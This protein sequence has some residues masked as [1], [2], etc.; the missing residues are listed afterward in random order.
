MNGAPVF[1]QLK[2]KETVSFPV[3]VFLYSGVF[4]DFFLNTSYAA[5]SQ[6]GETNGALLKR[7]VKG[8]GGSLATLQNQLPQARDVNL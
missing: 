7:R 8:R 2:E 5:T 6:K 3:I 1:L 4:L